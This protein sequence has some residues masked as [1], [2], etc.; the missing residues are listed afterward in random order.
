VSSLLSER[1]VILEKNTF[2]EIPTVT[3]DSEQSLPRTISDTTH[4][5][6]RNDRIQPAFVADFAPIL[7][8]R[9]L[10]HQ[11]SV[12]MEE[13]VLTP[14]M[15]PLSPSDCQWHPESKTMGTLSSDGRTF[16]KLEFDGRLSMVTEDEVKES[17]THRYLV[18]IEE[19]SAT[20]S[21]ADGFGFV[22]GDRLPCKRNIQKINSLFINKRGQACARLQGMDTIGHG[23]AHPVDKGMSVE[24]IVDL[25]NCSIAFT[26]FDKTDASLGSTSFNFADIIHHTGGKKGF[27]CA[28]IKHVDTTISFR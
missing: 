22:F 23:Y 27:F 26:V 15:L 7:E 6:S 1:P 21:A 28:V 9:A 14:L 12:Q 18:K 10:L 4:T 20:F 5:R 17:G 8:D 25:D 2:L 3:E 19:S 13:D 11:H 24:M 16:T